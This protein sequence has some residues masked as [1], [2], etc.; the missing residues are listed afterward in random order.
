[1]KKYLFIFF[2]A[3]LF[4]CSNV[5]AQHKG[6]KSAIGF[7]FSPDYAYRSLLSTDSANKL[8]K[9]I[10]TTPQNAI[11]GFTSGL[12]YRFNLLGTIGIE[13]GI[14]YTRKGWSADSVNS[15]SVITNL[16]NYNYAVVPIKMRINLP[17]GRRLVYINAGVIGGVLLDAAKTVSTAYFTGTLNSN[18][19]TIESV[20]SNKIYYSMVF[21]IGLDYRLISNLYFKIE[22]NFQR[23]MSEYS[24][25]TVKAFLNSGGINLGLLWGLK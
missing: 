11:I 25:E 23:T 22:P 20:V 17:S 24:K 7:T 5:M 12:S 8:F 3:N 6:Y 4:I 9:E 1:M 14:N 10:Q 19:T 2:I 13:T 16:F 15:Q 18:Q 21:G